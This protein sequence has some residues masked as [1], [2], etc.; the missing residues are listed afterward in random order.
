[1]LL[2]IIIKIQVPYRCM[3]DGAVV[4]STFPINSIMIG[5]LW[6]VLSSSF[7]FS[8]AKRH[9]SK[10]ASWLKLVFLCSHKGIKRG[11]AEKKTLILKSWFSQL[12]HFPISGPFFYNPNLRTL[13]HNL[14]S[15]NRCKFLG[16]VR[17]AVVG[18]W[19]H[20]ASLGEPCIK[21]SVNLFCHKFFSKRSASP[22]RMLFVKLFSKKK[23]STV[24]L[25]YA[26][27][28]LN[29][30]CKSCIESILTKNFGVFGSRGLTF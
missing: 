13:S 9:F 1:M 21:L 28:D 26:K 27:R 6:T 25:S 10:T 30:F 2:F 17:A 15:L 14:S 7:C 16:G 22:R 23:T 11:E 5:L 12:Y 19:A 29:L 20:P 24:K 18:A 8:F 4:F 3:H